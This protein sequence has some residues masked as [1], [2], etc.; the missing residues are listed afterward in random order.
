MIKIRK[1]NEEFYNAMKYDNYHEIFVNP[2]KKELD[3]VYNE[4]V[5]YSDYRSI[6]FIAKNDTKQL[7]VFNGNIL[8]ENA[9]RK[10]FNKDWRILLN[11]DYQLICGSIAKEDY[12]VTSSDSIESNI[13]KYSD[14]A[15]MYIKFVLKTDW[16]WLDKYI[17][18]SD[19]WN[20][21]A[22]PNLKK[23]LLEVE[24]GLEDMD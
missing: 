3:I 19:W 1:F 16:S 11:S 9:I 20:T 10:I 2:T 7:F 4:D 23:Q 22:I 8:H 18:F 5:K 15:Y 6:R 21:I 17:Y 12:I 24:Q 13:E 14:N